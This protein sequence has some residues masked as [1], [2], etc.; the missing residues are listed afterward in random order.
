[1]FIKTCY[2]AMHL[3]D[4]KARIMVADAG[5]HSIKVF[6]Q[7]D[8]GSFVLSAE[9]T[10]RPSPDFP[11][12][13]CPLCLAVTRQ[14]QLVVLHRGEAEAGVG[15]RRNQKS[16]SEG[17]IILLEGCGTFVRTIVPDLQ[18]ERPFTISCDS[19]DRI[20]LLHRTGLALFYLYPGEEKLPRETLEFPPS[21]KVDG[22]VDERDDERRLR[23]E[24]EERI[25]KLTRMSGTDDQI[26]V[27]KE[28]LE[29]LCQRA[30]RKRCGAGELYA[31]SE[32]S[33]ILQLSGVLAVFFLPLSAVH[34]SEKPAYTPTQ[35]NHTHAYLRQGRV[36]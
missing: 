22:E 15:S 35:C 17:S 1:M 10:G 4:G 3:P 36:E 19:V 12:L 8:G 18:F 5:S 34:P 24:M 14:G 29:A 25:L 7:G 6:Q 9:I 16:M 28:E 2:L 30:Q 31:V 23:V 20:T 32:A 13:N 26:Q 21:A 33:G 27:L 11:G